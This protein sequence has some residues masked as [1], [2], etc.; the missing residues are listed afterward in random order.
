MPAVGKAAKLDDE[1]NTPYPVLGLR[2]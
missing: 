2:K 1:S